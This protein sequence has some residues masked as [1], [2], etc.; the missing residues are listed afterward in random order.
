MKRNP[1]ITKH[2]ILDRSAHFVVSM[3]TLVAFAYI[4][5]FMGY[6]LSTKESAVYFIAGSLY[7]KT[8][9]ATW[10]WKIF[11]WFKTTKKS[12]PISYCSCKIPRTDLG[13]LQPCLDCGKLI[14]WGKEQ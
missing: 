2:V 9:E 11:Q 4:L 13:S 6:S 8:L 5:K 10:N 7:Q 1:P 14:D 3:L 12:K